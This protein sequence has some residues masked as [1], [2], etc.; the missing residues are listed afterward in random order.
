MKTVPFVKNR[1]DNIHCVNA[2]FR[3]V[4]Q[5]FFNEK[6]TW[7]EIDHLTKAIPGKTTWTF[8]GE[9]EFAKKGLQ[10]TNIEP[11][12]YRQMH[13]EGVRYL[14]K[15]LG[16]QTAHYYLTK[17]NITSV[18]PYIPEYL[19]L[20]RHETRSAS[21]EEIIQY[22]QRGCLVGAEV[23]S[24]ILNYRKGFDLHFVL[25]YDFDGIHLIL[26]DPG[27]PPIKSRKITVKQFDRCF[28]FEGANAGITV[29]RNQ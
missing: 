16:G 1:R 27:L 21:I 19:T 3:M 10:V 25:I 28:H 13:E 11:V 9:M 4:Y 29:F 5:Y 24:R 8:I 18:I 20:V 12:D 26:H 14:Q 7:K 23:N 22:I 2:V 15:T 17:S 6:L